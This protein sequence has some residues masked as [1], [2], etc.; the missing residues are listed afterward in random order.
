MS[1]AAD[2]ANVTQLLVNIR[3]AHS[4]DIKAKV[5]NTSVYTTYIGLYYLFFLFLYTPLNI[6]A[7][8][9]D[10]LQVV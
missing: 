5:E 4:E 3:C 2:V 6:S 9:T 8:Y 7:L 1:Q 10:R